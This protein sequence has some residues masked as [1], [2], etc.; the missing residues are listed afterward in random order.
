MNT[1]TFVR[2]DG[3]LGET[4]QFAGPAPTI[5]PSKGKWLLDVVPSYNADTQVATKEP[6]QSL[7]GSQI[8]YKVDNKSPTEI[9]KESKLKADMVEFKAVIKLP[10]FKQL[11]KKTRQE[12]ITMVQSAFPAGEQRDLITALALVAWAQTIVLDPNDA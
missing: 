4:K 10:A 2:A 6:V 3:T 1:F 11:R 7:S 5:H 9:A 8:S 12:V